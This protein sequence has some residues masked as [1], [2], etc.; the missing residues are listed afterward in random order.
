M[1]MNSLPLIEFMTVWRVSSTVYVV[2]SDERME[3]ETA[4]YVLYRYTPSMPML[5]RGYRSRSRVV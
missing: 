1:S 3:Y 2:S 4:D 5:D